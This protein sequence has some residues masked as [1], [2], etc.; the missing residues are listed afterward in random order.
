MKG[1][2]ESETKL[3]EQLRNFFADRLAEKATAEYF[4][5]MLGQVH[6]R[7]RQELVGRPH[8]WDRLAEFLASSLSEVRPLFV[9]YALPLVLF[10]AVVGFGFQQERVAPKAALRSGAVPLLSAD[11]SLTRWIS[12]PS[13]LLNEPRG[14]MAPPMV[15]PTTA[16]GTGE[17]RATKAKG[18]DSGGRSFVK[19]LPVRYEASVDF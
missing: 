16:S 18:R 15:A 3:N 1:K 17:E 2:Q 9:R 13:D 10:G 19:V 4:D 7:L 5:G 8:W 11:P 14:N 12:T 6:R